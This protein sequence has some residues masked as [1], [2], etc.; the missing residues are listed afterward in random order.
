MAIHAITFRLNSDSEYERRYVSLIGAI[1]KATATT[2]WSEPT[3]FFLIESTSNSKELAEWINQNSLLD[4]SKDLLLVINLTSKGHTPLG[5]IIDND[6]H[7]L[8]ARR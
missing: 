6:L 7:T 5:H 1:E 3:S 2:F 4:P 8:M